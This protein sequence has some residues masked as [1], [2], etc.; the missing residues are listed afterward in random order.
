[1]STFNDAN[2]PMGTSTPVQCSSRQAS[3]PPSMSEDD[4]DRDFWNLVRTIE[5]KVNIEIVLNIEI[6]LKIEI[7][8]H[9]VHVNI[10]VCMKYGI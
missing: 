4:V 3:G 8:Q 7:F 9:K 6:F 10:L 1:V 2:E 5:R